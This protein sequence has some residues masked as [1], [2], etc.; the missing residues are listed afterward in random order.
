ML[1][2]MIVETEMQIKMV[3]NLNEIPCILYANFY[4]PKRNV[5]FQFD[6]WGCE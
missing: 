6:K 4:F 5:H 3:E 1:S 2:Q